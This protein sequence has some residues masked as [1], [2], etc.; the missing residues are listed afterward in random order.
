[1]KKANFSF[2]LFLYESFGLFLYESFGL[3]L[4]ESLLFEE[5]YLPLIWV[6]SIRVI[7]IRKLTFLGTVPTFN[8]GYFY[9]KAYFLRNSTYL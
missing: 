7:S 8:L 2:G 6:I 9:T 1:M 5:Q 3:F 4:Y